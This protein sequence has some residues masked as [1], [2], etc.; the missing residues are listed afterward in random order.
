MEIFGSSS[1]VSISNPGL[2]K[3]DMS[4]SW[5]F[6]WA[7]PRTPSSIRSQ[8]LG[9]P[10]YVP[11]VSR[12]ITL[13]CRHRRVGF[14][15]APRRALPGILAV[16]SWR[17]SELLWTNWTKVL[18]HC[19]LAWLGLAWA[20]RGQMAATVTIDKVYFET[21]L[22]RCVEWSPKL[23][24]MVNRWLTSAR[25]E[26]VRHICKADWLLQTCLF[27][28]TAYIRQRSDDFP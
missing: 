22:R 6:T 1:A 20:S 15:K 17:L 4:N 28:S 11:R 10:R 9:A 27:I 25:A 16:E 26:F 8:Q 23:N 19:L 7:L 3:H 13:L 2:S 18:Q 14:W 24:Y 12:R 5:G 21:L